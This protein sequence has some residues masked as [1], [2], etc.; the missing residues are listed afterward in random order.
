MKRWG[1]VLAVILAA[2]PLARAAE[3]ESYLK[4]TEAELNAWGV[5]VAEFQKRAEKAGATTRVELDRQVKTIE[6]EITVARS[7]LR[8][9]KKSNK[10]TWRDLRNSA[11]ETIRDI[12]QT[13]KT[14]VAFLNQNE[15]EGD[16]R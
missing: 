13:Y 11:D 12:K 6:E 5:K 7:K 8:Q 16:K 10:G 3:K 4:E 15:H 1:L 2:C 14:A 9:V